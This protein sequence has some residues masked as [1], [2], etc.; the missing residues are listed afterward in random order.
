MQVERREQLV[1][2]YN[3][4]FNGTRPREYDGTYLRF[5]GMSP[6]IQLRPH[7]L[8]AIAHTIYGGNT[9]LAHQVGA[10]KTFE[11][12]AAAMESKR[13]GLCNKSLFVVPNHLTEQW[14]AEFMR[15]YPSANILVATAKDFEAQNRKR[16]CSKISTGNYF[17]CQ[18]RDEQ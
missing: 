9:L 14:G 17:R 2:K 11:M 8:N 15:L 1:D 6:E 16:L 7:Q 10:G 12:V 3:E 13:L 4:L 5:S 18:D